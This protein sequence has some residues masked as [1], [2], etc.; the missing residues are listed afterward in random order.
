MI[1]QLIAGALE[2]DRQHLRSHGESQETAI[3][4][5]EELTGR[6]ALLAGA[7]KTL[8]E[9]ERDIL[10]ERRLKDNPATLEELMEVTELRRWQAG[11]LGEA[12]VKV[13]ALMPIPPTGVPSVPN[14]RKL[15]PCGMPKRLVM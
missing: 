15:W 11:E 4:D 3:A 8:N 9:R 7:L 1:L 6:K 12:F 5:R 14:G 13:T 2:R 10:M